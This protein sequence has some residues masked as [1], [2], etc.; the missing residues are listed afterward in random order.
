M[1]ASRTLVLLATASA[2]LAV[3]WA[4][5]QPSPVVVN[6]NDLVGLAAGPKEKKV[7]T[8]LVRKKYVGRTVELTAQ[9]S[10]TAS[11]DPK[12]GKYV[13]RATAE[14]KKGRVLIGI[15]TAEETEEA[16]Q[17]TKIVVIGEAQLRGGEF[18]I[19]N[20][21]VRVEDQSPLPQVPD[22]PVPWLKRRAILK[23]LPREVSRLAFSPDSQ[24]VA[25]SSPDGVIRLSDLATGRQKARL[26]SRDPDRPEVVHL[27]FSPDGKMLAAGRKRGDIVLWDVLQRKEMSRVRSPGLLPETLAFSPDSQ[28]V[29]VLTT[30][31]GQVGSQV[32]QWEAATGKERATISPEKS[33]GKKGALSPDGA[34][35][36]VSGQYIDKKAVANVYSV[37]LW[38]IAEN[39]QLWEQRWPTRY[40]EFEGLSLAWTSDSKVLLV[41]GRFPAKLIKLIDPLTG[42][43]KATLPGEFGLTGAQG[44]VTTDGK[45]MALYSA[46][47]LSLVDLAKGQDSVALRGYSGPFGLAPNGAQL[48]TGGPLSEQ[49]PAGFLVV[50]DVVKE[51]LEVA[52]QRPKARVTLPEFRRPVRSVAFSPDGKTLFSADLGDYKNRLPSLVKVWDVS[53]GKERPSPFS[54]SSYVS[55]LA[56]APDGKTLAVQADGRGQLWDVATGKVRAPAQE[57]SAHVACSP[58]GKA[59]ATVRLD[60]TIQLRPLEKGRA[61]TAISVHPKVVRFIAFSPDGKTLAS[62][63]A[64]LKDPQTK[65]VTLWDVA[66]GQAKTTL[67]SDRAG[68]AAVA[69]SPDGKTLA[70][71]QTDGTIR[72]WDV[73]TGKPTVSLAQGKCIAFS[74]DGKT[75]AVGGH[76]DGTVWLWDVAARRPTAILTGHTG[77]VL[78]VVFSPDGRTLASGALA[79]A[80]YWSRGELKL[81]DVPDSMSTQK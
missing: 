81:W 16:Q 36:A 79:P 34:Y 78:T 32:K 8:A 80:K 67:Q 75:L 69:F 17:A 27:A 7:A 38:D 61:P 37:K 52:S 62:G 76:A 3:S 18:W 35:M 68:F 41:S 50:W 49:G 65:Q 63:D 72:L 6:P 53:T 59:L 1:S 71:A 46:V 5:S 23:G 28:T 45:Q 20:A 74:P 19:D 77:P 25:T 21:R 55:H 64:E 51:A 33:G 70:G 22:S 42:K 58:D 40:L 26:D 24:T 39:K 9:F 31:S 2:L 13:L 29:R 30:A 43:E 4:A 48:V 15:L 14:T 56:V 60:G 54:K 44:T 66:T 73:A 11:K 57:G 47:G 10:G 12:S